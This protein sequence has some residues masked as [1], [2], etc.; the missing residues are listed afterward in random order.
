MKGIFPA[1][2]DAPAYK[3]FDGWYS[4]PEGGIRYTESSVCP[5]VDKLTLFAHWTNKTYKIKYDGNG[6]ER[7]SMENT[8]AVCNT[9]IDVAENGFFK[10]GYTVEAWTTNPDGSGTKILANG[11]KAYNLVAPYA[12]PGT[13]VTLYAK[14]IPIKDVQVTFNADGGFIVEPGTNN[15]TRNYT[16]NVEYKAAYGT[17]PTA[18]H[19]QG[20][21][22][23]G[24]KDE[25]GRIVDE[26]STVFNANNHS[27]RAVWTTKQYTIHF[28]GNK[29][30]Y[31]QVDDLVFEKGDNKTLPNCLFDDGVN[32]YRWSTTP[33][34]FGDTFA[35]GDPVERVLQKTN[36]TEITLY[37][38][39][40]EHSIVY[41]DGFTGK[42]I[43]KVDGVSHKYTAIDGIEI[44]GLRF[45][46]W[47]LSENFPLGEL[48][49]LGEN[50]ILAE[51]LYFKA[52]QSRSIDVPYSSSSTLY[53]YSI[54][55]RSNKN[56]YSIIYHPYD[57]YNCPKVDNFDSP[58]KK[59]VTISKPD[60]DG[61]VFFGWVKTP[62]VTGVLQK[63]VELSNYQRC[64]VLYPDWI[65][66]ERVL[67]LKDGI[68]GKQDA[69]MPLILPGETTFKLNSFNTPNRDDYNFGGW[70][71]KDGTIYPEGSEVLVPAEGLELTATW[72]R[73]EYTIKYIDSYTK[74][75]LHT[76]TLKSDET[77][78]YIPPEVGGVKFKGWTYL[79]DL[80]DRRSISSG[81]LVSSFVNTRDERS[82]YSLET[83]YEKTEVETGKI[84]VVYIWNG[85][86]VENGPTKPTY[87]NISTGEIELTTV[88]PDKK[89]CVFNGW[90]YRPNSSP[91]IGADLKTFNVNVIYRESSPV[92]FNQKGSG[93]LVL[94]ACWKSK[95][96]CTLD[97]NGYPGITNPITISG[98]PGTKVDLKDYSKLFKNKGDFY[99]SGWGESKDDVTLAP[100]GSFTIP[101]KDYVLYAIPRN[102]TCTIKYKDGFSGEQ[103]GS[104]ATVNVGSEVT[105]PAEATFYSGYEFVGWSYDI[106]DQ[107]VDAVY[108]AV[109]DLSIGES[110]TVR[111]SIELYATYR[112]L[113]APDDVF[114][115]VYNPNG[116]VGGPGTALLSPGEHTVDVTN[117]P[118]YPGYTFEGWHPVNYRQYYVLEPEFPKDKVSKISSDEYGMDVTLYAVWKEDEGN[119]VRDMLKS[120]YDASAFDDTHFTREYTSSE[121]ERIDGTTY[122]IVN[123]KR[124]GN[125]Q[126]SNSFNSTA[127]VLRFENGDWVLRSYGTNEPISENIKLNILMSHTNNASVALEFAFEIGEAFSDVA[128][129]AIS[130]YCPA[131]GYVV[132]GTK[133]LNKIEELMKS[134]EEYE[135]LSDFV[136]DTLKDEVIDLT[137]D[138]IKGEML[139]KALEI[140]SER[141]EVPEKILESVLNLF[142][143]TEQ[144][145]ANDFA[146]GSD[147]MDPFGE[148][149]RALEIFRQRVSSN[150][151][152][153]LANQIPDCVTK[154][155]LYVKQR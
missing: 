65:W 53:V 115:I 29:Y 62:G 22:F 51:D 125:S 124:A 90:A 14:W 78:S 76:E 107:R 149:D 140:E 134:R 13:V 112:K 45:A 119:T 7:G 42:E 61:F 19:P 54:Y 71:A 9:K 146:T 41:M 16:K 108:S 57:G 37:A 23:G 73:R 46:G 145:V 133:Y 27:L 138:K 2:V 152:E 139:G 91:S 21:I 80:F 59:S 70:K 111:E 101:Y 60:K 94:Y 11:G 30:S 43:K 66:T 28:D 102:K 98:L 155:F 137:V 75:I 56:A 121:W 83:S 5:N 104:V 123:T 106:M 105:P 15:R 96:S 32:F 151:F 97:P 6:A 31:G 34:C 131:V 68:D 52:G 129:D 64:V 55:E 20:K 126:T 1:K 77:V 10:T 142:I 122:Y 141:G 58:G 79:A 26:S 143:S 50:D 44:P 93:V 118:S 48:P 24:W 113:A 109:P 63:E 144:A 8:P 82:V 49:L 18:V 127:F 17:L 33:D 150:G 38:L 25:M 47:M 147:N 4:A 84:T 117:V 110:I 116:G 67:K 40:Y 128:V 148:Y 3:M 88:H 81:A 72:E 136:I 120:E 153:D 114:R 69:E 100:E 74:E 95:Y 86:D 132:K 154:I 92:T 87:G 99:L 85:K 130:I 12:E 103:I 35:P 89:G 36:Q 39:W 135:E